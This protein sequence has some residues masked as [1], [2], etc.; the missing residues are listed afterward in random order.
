FENMQLIESKAFDAEMRSQTMLKEV[1]ITS[2]RKDAN[3]K[4][5]EM[6]TVTLSIDRIKTLPVVFG[7]V[8][9]LK[10]IQLLPGVQ[11]AGE[12]NTG[13]YVR[14]GGPDQNLVLLDEAV[15][16]NTGHLF[17]FFSVF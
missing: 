16:Y 4:N 10:A 1:E 12:G 8:E 13:F 9:I 11:N 6:G 14:G 2:A 7:E 17:G 15:V 5:T 3:V